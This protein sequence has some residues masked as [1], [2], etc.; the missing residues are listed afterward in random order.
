MQAWPWILAELFTQG[1]RPFYQKL[2]IKLFCSFKKKAEVASPRMLVFPPW[3]LWNC[4]TRKSD[5]QMPRKLLPLLFSWSIRTLC[6]WVLSQKKKTW[7]QGGDRELKGL[8]RHSIFELP[9]GTAGCRLNGWRLEVLSQGHWVPP[10]AAHTITTCMSTRADGTQNVPKARFYG[11]ERWEEKNNPPRDEN[12]N[13]KKK[14]NPGVLTMLHSFQQMDSTVSWHST[15]SR[16]RHQ[17]SL[18]SVFMSCV[19]IKNCLFLKKK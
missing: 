14:K 2:E 8:G 9:R 15:F 7:R 3:Q 18:H 13:A 4:L 11:G 5:K 19:R 1:G 17:M 16:R 12:R 6:P 10:S